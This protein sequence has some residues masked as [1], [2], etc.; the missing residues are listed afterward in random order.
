M[1]K[2]LALTTAILMTAGPVLAQDDMKM[3]TDYDADGDGMLSMQE[4]RDG[5]MSAG[6]TGYDADGDGMVTT[7][8]FDAGREGM[9]EM[10][11]SD[12]YDID[13][14]GD[15][16]EDEFYE[17]DFDRFDADDNDLLD[18]DEYNMFSGERQMMM[19]RDG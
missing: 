12:T 15:I 6:F 19:D 13:A 4:Y 8:E 2:T 7:D 1:R 9:E 10:V 18:E 16:S 5:D 14:S 3:M 17:A 11:G